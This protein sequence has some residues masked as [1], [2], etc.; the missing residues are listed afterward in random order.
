MTTHTFLTEALGWGLGLWLIGYI[1]GIVFF[2]I[3]PPAYVGWAIT[4]IGIAIT[5]WVLFKKVKSVTMKDFAIIAVAWMLI[6][7]VCDY[8]FLVQ[9]FHPADGYYKLDVYI[10]YGVTLLLPFLVGWRK[11]IPTSSVSA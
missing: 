6:A 10:Y 9:V 3:M 4:P 5:L 8:F 11:R 7:I 2:F 1:L